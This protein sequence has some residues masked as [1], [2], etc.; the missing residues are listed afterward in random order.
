LFKQTFFEQILYVNQKN[1]YFKTC[2][3]LFF[4]SVLLAQLFF[5]HTLGSNNWN[6]NILVKVSVFALKDKIRDF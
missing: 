4:G 2:V 6:K 1:K 5:T 3:F